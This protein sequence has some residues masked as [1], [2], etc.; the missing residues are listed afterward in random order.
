MNRKVGAFALATL[1]PIPVLIA[2]GIWGG[3]VMAFACVYL[4][5][6]TFLLDELIV[7]AAEDSQPGV[8][9]PAARWLSILLGMLH[10]PVLLFA[11]ATISGAFGA[12]P[13]EQVAA[14]F[15]F[16]LY[17]GQVSYSNAHELIHSA[18]RL[19][20][21]LGTLVYSST[22]Y[23]HHVTAHRHIHHRYV[24]S[25]DDPN[26][27]RLG[28]SFYGFAAR[29]WTSSARLGLKVENRSQR[30]RYGRIKPLRHMYAVYAGIG[31][32]M[33]VG[34]TWAFGVAGLI[35]FLLLSIYA[36]AQILLADYV[37]HYGLKR[38]SLPN[39][40]L[41]PIGVEHSWNAPHPVSAALML[42]APRHS[43][44]H[45]HPSKPFEALDLPEEDEAPM[46]PYSLPAM[47]TIALFPPFW[48]R[49]MDDR[50]AEWSRDGAVTAMA[51][52]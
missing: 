33:M 28:E 23:G 2:A 38:A 52:E 47:S 51:A 30:A 3:W 21:W 13:I 11:A 29:A 5:T 8:E 32:T 50:A 14:L 48:R 49:A 7:F 43:D 24:G 46:L 40:K 39:G 9:F 15:A 45:A 19:P 17:F 6:L 31:L 10:I 35:S 37:Q 42:N 12:G 22:L 20:F 41:E 4:S 36:T 27:A 25:D 34:V 16:G 18:R 26:T 44:H 1:L